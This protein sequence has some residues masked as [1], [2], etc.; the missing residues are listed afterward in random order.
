MNNPVILLCDCYYLFSKQTF[1]F[2]VSSFLQYWPFFQLYN[3]HL[4]SLFN[5]SLFNPLLITPEAE[6]RSAKEPFK[7]F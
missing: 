1:H 5:H 2:T 7:I 4:F 6:L 3:P